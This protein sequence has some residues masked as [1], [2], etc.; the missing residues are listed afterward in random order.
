[1][2][3]VTILVSL[4]VIACLSLRA[5][6]TLQ[7]YAAK[8]KFPQGSAISEVNVV[9]ENGLL[10]LNSSM[11]NSSLEKTADDK[12]Y[13]PANSGTIAFIRNDAKKITGIKFDVQHISID[14]TKEEKEIS[15]TVEPVP[16]YKST[17][18]IKNLPAMLTVEIED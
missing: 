15:G 18:P 11:G 5:E 17:F 2:K 4:F 3:K 7:Q 13:M 9:F 16:M 14:G 6:E 1:M 8:Y 12:F 10:Q